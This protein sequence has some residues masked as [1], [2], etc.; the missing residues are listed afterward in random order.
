MYHRP[1]TRQRAHLQQWLY[2][3]MNPL[4]HI[5]GGYVGPRHEPSVLPLSSLEQQYLHCLQL[6]KHNSWQVDA[7]RHCHAGS[8]H[9]TGR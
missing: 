6:R 3:V 4:R 5:Q 7:D 1:C 8:L 9:W 2:T